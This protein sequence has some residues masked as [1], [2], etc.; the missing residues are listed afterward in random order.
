MA[1]G[2]ERRNKVIGASLAM[3][4]MVTLLWHGTPEPASSLL[5]DLTVTAGRPGSAASKDVSGSTR[6]HHVHMLQA[7]GDRLHVL[8][9]R[10]ESLLTLVTDELEEACSDE[11]N[12]AQFCKNRAE[13]EDYAEKWEPFCSKKLAPTPECDQEKQSQ[14]ELKMIHEELIKSCHDVILNYLSVYGPIPGTCN[15]SA[16]QEP[17]CQ[18][19][20]CKQL[21]ATEHEYA[22]AASPSA[23]T[24]PPGT[25]ASECDS[26]QSMAEWLQC[27]QRTRSATAFSSNPKHISLAILRLWTWSILHIRQ[28]EGNSDAEHGTGLEQCMCVRC[29]RPSGSLVC[30]DITTPCDGGG[31][32]TGPDDVF[33]K[34]AGLLDVPETE[35]DPDCDGPDGCPK[36]MRAEESGGSDAEASEDANVPSPPP[37]SAP[38]AE[39]CDAIQDMDAWLECEQKKRDIPAPP[40]PPPP[41]ASPPPP[42][43]AQDCDAIIDMAA[44]LECEEKK[45]GGR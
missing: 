40:P 1:W 6:L 5:S 38:A 21:I 33:V 14:H 45:R 17:A 12:W 2:E 11:D 27:E 18:V 41:P 25:A 13:D 24:M 31:I 35:D 39:D 10:G 22:A 26:I 44:W 9:E 28:A 16:P 3:G 15:A 29:K 8:A 7:A 34:C 32:E 19:A 4:M 23:P 20:F 36:I 42:S 37:P 30:N 43:A